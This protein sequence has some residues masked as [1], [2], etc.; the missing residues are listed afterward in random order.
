MNNNSI[1]N[2]DLYNFENIERFIEAVKNFEGEWDRLPIELKCKFGIIH[3]ELNKFG[4]KNEWKKEF[5]WATGL[6]N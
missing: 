2:G 1:D 3:V 6:W 5:Q 4:G